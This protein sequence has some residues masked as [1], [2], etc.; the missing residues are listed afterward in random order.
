MFLDEPKSNNGMR[1]L[2]SL[3]NFLACHHARDVVSVQ[4]AGICQIQVINEG[5]ATL[6]N[7]TFI[8]G[9]VF[10]LTSKVYRAVSSPFLFCSVLA[11]IV[12]LFRARNSIIHLTSPRVGTNP[13]RQIFERAAASV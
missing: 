4:W 10:V 12:R 13:V 2:S 6:E 9:F 3:L 11:R 7:I 1:E 8:K 5:V